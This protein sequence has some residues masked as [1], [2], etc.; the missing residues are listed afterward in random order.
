MGFF[1]TTP[2]KITEKELKDKVGRDLYSN[3]YFRNLPDYREYV[4][5]NLRKLLD[6]DYHSSGS[7]AG[8]S[9]EEV[10]KFVDS[11]RDPTAEDLQEQHRYNIRHGLTEKQLES[12]EEILK[13][14]L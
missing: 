9:E 8:I 3:P 14:H 6:T 13:R 12:L 10:K 4:T 5:N 7:H 11:L 2:P 1:T